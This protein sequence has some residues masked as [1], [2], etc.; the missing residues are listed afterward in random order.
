MVGQPAGSGGLA[1][2]FD[3]AA[4]R[5]TRRGG[6]GRQPMTHF[7]GTHLVK[8]D[9]KGRVSVPASFRGAL[10]RIGDMQL[11]LRP[12]HRW[13]C[14]EVWPREA[15]FELA[16]G[17]DNFAEFSDEHDDLGVTIFGDAH[18]AAPDG[19]G[20]MNLPQPLV[21]HAALGETVAFVGVGKTFQIWSPEG[22]EQRKAEARA[23]TTSRGLQ[24]PPRKG[25]EA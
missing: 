5:S 19:E 25:G 20:R 17:L 6:R 23:R 4:I 21:D 22:I 9:K 11:F 13:P 15:F 2:R 10:S 16:G 8:L 14:I 24:M 7:M 3:P 18:E 1:G 12:S